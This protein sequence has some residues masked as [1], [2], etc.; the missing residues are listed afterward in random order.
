MLWQK[1]ANTFN[2]FRNTITGQLRAGF[3][4]KIQRKPNLCSQPLKV[5]LLWNPFAGQTHPTLPASFSHQLFSKFEFTSFRAESH[6]EEKK[7]YISNIDLICMQIRENFT[8]NVK[9]W[10][11]ILSKPLQLWP[12]ATQ[13]VSTAKET[14]GS[15]LFLASLLELE[16]SIFESLFQRRT[17]KAFIR[18]LHSECCCW[19]F[20]FGKHNC[21][22]GLLT[23]D[24]GHFH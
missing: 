10:L 5:E 18:I 20:R 8:S 21:E 2:T 6:L 9:G 16:S 22:A 1:L 7:K 23:Q 15:T 14:L 24:S 4:L 19:C 12:D 11:K 13:E 3:Y 17:L